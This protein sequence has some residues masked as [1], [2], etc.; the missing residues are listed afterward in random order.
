V[1]GGV[2]ARASRFED[3]IA[4]QKAR[5]L[6]KAVYE[7]TM[8]SAF[9]TDRALATQIRRAAVSIM[10]NLAEG[11]ERGRLTEFHQYVSMAKGSCGEVR[12]GLYVA[13]DAGYLDHERFKALID[14]SEQV[15]RILGA[16]RA[17]LRSRK[18]REHVD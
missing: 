17:S 1:L 8:E 11:F 4:W 14:L 5:E 3:L 15:G 12:S 10:G 2:V 13:L 6:T 9:A 18:P 16:L 7:A